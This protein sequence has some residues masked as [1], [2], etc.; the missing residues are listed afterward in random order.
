M[1][2]QLPAYKQAFIQA[3]ISGGI[4]KFGTFELKSKRI[5]PYFFNAGLFHTARLA[6]AIATAFAHTIIAAQRDGGL[7]YDIVFGPAYKGIPL[8][9]SI[10]VKLG[11]LD[12]ACLDAVSYSFD[13]KE[14]KDHGE[15]GSIVGAPLKGKRVL[16]VDDVITAGTAKREAIEK[17]QREGGIVAGIVVAVDRMEKL[18]AADGDD[19][20]PGPSAIGELRKEFGIPI[21]SIVDLDDI[22]EAM[23]AVAS[24]EDLRRTEEY[25]QKYKAT[26]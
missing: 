23:K 10:A 21:F 12:P 7:E 2:A 18:P 25:R 17:I 5:S 8:A 22:I 11:E 1:S 14:A 26:D 4:L 3:S 9:S 20:K 16:I 13:R 19:S 6:G 15:G 24:P